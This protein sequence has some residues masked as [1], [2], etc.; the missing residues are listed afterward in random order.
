MVSY[1]TRRI[2]QSFVTLFL[3]SV[4]TF[5][6][7]HTAP[8][9]PIRSRMKYPR[10]SS[11]AVAQLRQEFGLD[12]PIP[13]RYLKWTSHVIQGDLG[14]S[15]ISRRP[16]VDE[17]LDRLGNTFYLMLV[18]FT[19]T[20]VVS[21]AISI[22]SARRQYSVFDIVATTMTFMGR[23]IPEFWLGI[24]LISIFYGTLNNPM[25]GKPLLPAGGMYTIGSDFDILDRIIHLLLPV[26][27]LA[28]VWTASYSRFLRSSLLE[29]I[30]LDYITTARAKGLS[31]YHILFRHTLRN[32]LLPLVTL[33]ALDLPYMFAGSLYIEIIFS[34]PGMGRLFF[35]AAMKR[36]YPIL[37]GII[38]IMA[39][40]IVLFNL[41]ADI[42]YARLDPRILYDKGTT[43]RNN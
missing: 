4:C 30:H 15:L 23:A 9:D 20:V 33:I 39:T 27:T 10:L 16:V 13:V 7:V 21:L 40:F 28:I 12:D 5:L 29:I 31:E 19:V 8:G 35:D 2:L 26:A 17:I 24:M 34:W 37:M 22:I 32:A 11:E 36:D 6:L 41:L 25:T 18:A 38:M 1:L 14:Y 43:M 42:L 3:I